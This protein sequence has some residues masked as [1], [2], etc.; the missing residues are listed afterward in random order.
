MNLRRRWRVFVELARGRRMPLRDARGKLALVPCELPA[1]KARLVVWLAIIGVAGGTA[2]LLVKDGWLLVLVCAAVL[3]LYYPII[4]REAMIDLATARIRYRVRRGCCPWCNGEL[5]PA[6]E[7]ERRRCLSC[8]AE[9]WDVLGVQP[10][11]APKD[12]KEHVVA[13][14]IGM[15]LVGLVV[16]AVGLGP[17]PTDPWGVVF[18]WVGVAL[19][20][21]FLGSIAA[22]HARTPWWVLLSSA[23]PGTIYGLVLLSG[24]GHTTRAE[25]LLVASC[26][27]GAVG[28]AGARLGH[29]RIRRDIREREGRACAG[30]GYDMR[31]CEPGDV[32]PECQS[33]WRVR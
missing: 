3:A 26:L 5:T 1:R 33:P 25:A 21:W 29:R 8:S 31:A 22:G 23:I 9:W 15:G 6:S 7:S 10:G 17:V 13:I 32:C 12:Q 27:F 2:I 19:V 18:I 30:C 16:G 11:V 4:V 20:V 14:G 28:A 24:S